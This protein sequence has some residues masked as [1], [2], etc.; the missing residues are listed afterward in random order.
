MAIRRAWRTTFGVAWP[1]SLCWIKTGSQVSILLPGIGVGITF[2][3][4]DWNY[5]KSHQGY[6]KEE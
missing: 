3:R 2:A 5:G 1:G 6:L 4:P